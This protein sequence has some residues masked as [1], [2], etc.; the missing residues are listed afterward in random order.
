MSKKKIIQMPRA[1]IYI[2][3]R[4]L[5]RILRMLGIPGRV[6]PHILRVKV[7]G[8]IGYH[9]ILG[10]LKNITNY[11]IRDREREEL[12]RKEGDK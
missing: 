12:N 4:E 3:G 8:F 9:H 6:S 1:E 10:I 2:S 7:K 5:D 11:L